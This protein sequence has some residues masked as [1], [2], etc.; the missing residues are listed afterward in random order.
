MLKGKQVGRRFHLRLYD[1]MMA[2][3]RKLALLLAILFL[4]LWIMLRNDMVSWP[5]AQNAP[6]IL[7]GGLVSAAYTLFA[8]IGP[9]TSYVQPRQNHVRVQTPIYRLNISYRRIVGVRPVD[10]TK[11]FPPNQQPRRDRKVLRTFSGQTAVGIDMHAWPFRRWVLK[12]FLSRYNL[13]PERPGFIFLADDWIELSNAISAQIDDYRS[14]QIQ[15][16]KSPG[17]SAAD[18]LNHDS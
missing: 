9:L 1:R 8:W 15:R 6:W 3:Y 17:F 13:A 12:L 2:R 5:S 16:P 11:T 4:A 18:I 7:A 14:D 10:F